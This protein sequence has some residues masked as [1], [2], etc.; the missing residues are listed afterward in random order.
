MANK[1]LFKSLIGKLMPATDALNEH[2]A[3]AYALTPKQQLAQYA[4]TGCLNST[5]YVSADEQLSKVLE[6][7]EQVDAEFIAKTALYARKRG[8]MK[9]MP[10]L[11]CAVLSVKDRALLNA[12]FPRVIDNAKMLRNFVQIMRSGVVGRKSFGSAPKRLVREWLDARDPVSL[13]K[14]NVGQDPSLADIVKMVHPKPKDPNRE[15]L[16]GYFIG[17][18]HNV[19]A[20]PDLVRNFEA[21]KKGEVNDRGEVPDVPFQML[22]AL[23]LGTKE[24]T[25]IARRAPW[26]MTRMNLNTF[27]R[28]EVF[29]DQEMS[30]MIADRLRDRDKVRKARVFPYQLMVAYTMAAA[31]RDIPPIVANAL[32]D[33]MEVAT[34]NVPDFGGKVYVFPDVSGSMQSPATGYRKGATSAVRCLDIAALVAATVLRKNPDAEVIPFESKVVRVRLNPRDSVMTNAKKLAAL[35]AG[36]TNCSAPLAFLNKI[37]AD[38]DLVIYVSDNE[39]WVDAPHYGRYGGSATKTMKEWANFKSR[40]PKA[41]MVCIDIQPYGTVQAKGREDILNIGGFSDQVFEVIAEFARG[42]LNADHW[43]GVI[44]EVIV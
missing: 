24:W 11:L 25:E 14:D 12:I 15:A 41:G 22:T 18:D 43:I 2:Q 35:P 40:N 4:V 10:A 8:H 17:R 29:R 30:K 20:L 5:F 6:L 28:H 32:Q 44:E 16:F 19:E 37:G 23:E 3:P 36:G 27:A 34:A 38:G 33:A 13:F 42:G 31:N 26:Q 39:S 9:D 1:R 21:F 7:C